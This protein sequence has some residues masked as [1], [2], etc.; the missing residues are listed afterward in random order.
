MSPGILNELQSMPEFG[1]TPASARGCALN[2]SGV[3]SAFVSLG[4]SRLVSSVEKRYKTR[5]STAVTEA[6]ATS[7]TV[8]SAHSEYAQ[9]V[10]IRQRA[11]GFIG[12]RVPRDIAKKGGPLNESALGGA[13]NV[14]APHQDTQ[15]HHGT[16][17]NRHRS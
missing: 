10:D 5:L 1:D 4:A 14:V 9:I 17:R 2:N 11:Y 16:H 8:Q 6:I 13:D 7:A 3:G 15:V 12:Y